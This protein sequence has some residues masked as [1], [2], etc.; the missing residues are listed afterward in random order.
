MQA[1]FK[2]TEKKY[3]ISSAKAEKLTELLLDGHMVPDGTG[4]YLV[5][6]LYFDDDN[7]NVIT[8]SIAKPPYKEKMRLRCYGTLESA[9]FAFLELKK[10]YDGIVYKRRISIP[11]EC[12]NIPLK[13]VLAETQTQIARELEYHMVTT[14]VQA[15]VFVGYSRTALSGIGED[16]DLRITMDTDVHYRLNELN[17]KYPGKGRAILPEDAV[18]LEIK[19][20]FSIPLWLATFLSEN[21]IYSASFSKVGTCY[22][23]YMQH[24]QSFTGKDLFIMPY[25]GTES[26]R[27]EKE[28][29]A[30]V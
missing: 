22:Q 15:K 30:V 12:L 11:K 10:K 1:V 28:L 4:N 21:E 26:V 16:E 27:T 3:M 8:T 23:D 29:M 9:K 13:N 18:L 19:S 7:W 25:A 20:P 2:R 14:G 17:F 5:Q 6:N 24:G